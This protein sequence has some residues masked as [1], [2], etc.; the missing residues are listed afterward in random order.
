MGTRSEIVVHDGC[1][2]VVLFK[3]W[4][5]YVDYMIPL[6]EG[7][8]RYAVEL[9]GDH[10]HWLSYPEDVAAML[11][12]Y[13]GEE[14]KKYA[15]EMGTHAK[16]DIRP[17]GAIND[18]IDYVYFIDVSGAVRDRLWTVHAYE[19][20]ERLWPLPRGRRDAVYRRIV[21]GG[22]APEEYLK[23]CGEYRIR[24]NIARVPEAIMYLISP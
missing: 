5:G 9:C 14:A 7:A 16:P 19:V 15:R 6:F 13:D 22:R 24:L 10:V 3:H 1:H 4:D 21:R 17:V 18:L 2:M 20:Q 8:A 23:L 11:I 12:C